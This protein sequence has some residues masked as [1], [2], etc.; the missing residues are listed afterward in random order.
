K[1]KPIEILNISKQAFECCNKD[2]IF[3]I[4]NESHLIIEIVR[5]KSLNLGYLLGKMKFLDIN[6]ME[7]FK[8]FDGLKYFKIEFSEKVDDG[9]LA[10]IE[11]IVNNSFDMTK[12]IKLE[13]PKILKSELF[14]DLNHD[15]QIALLKLET[16]NQKGLLAFIA[17][18]FDEFGVDIVDAK[19]HTQKNIARD[20]FLIEKNESLCE[21]L[22][23]IID[24][25]C[26]E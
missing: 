10:F 26:V 17:K 6:S 14:F 22:D 21:K 5:Q 9:D 12:I 11:E 3:K 19:I 20:L 2:Y 4:T 15:K 23:D 18:V 25:L 13:K 8:L 1:Y 7:I 24:R 16:K